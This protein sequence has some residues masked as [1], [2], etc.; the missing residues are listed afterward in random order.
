M[1]TPVRLSLGRKDRWSQAEKALVYS[2]RHKLSSEVIHSVTCGHG[3]HIQDSCVP[4]WTYS[5]LHALKIPPVISHP[6]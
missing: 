6:Q 5:S 3:I 1:S 4:V 2:S